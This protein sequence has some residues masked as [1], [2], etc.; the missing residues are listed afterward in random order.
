M[1]P[2]TQELMT[3]HEAA[4][5]FRRSRSWLRQQKDLLRV[6][7][8][9]GQP[10]YHLQLCRAY[11]LGKVCRLNDDDLRQAQLRALA[12]ACGLNESDPAIVEPPPATVAR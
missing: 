6:A 11:V 8:P 2:S 10:L 12:A 4:R 3:P 5:W 1:T 9:N 7:S